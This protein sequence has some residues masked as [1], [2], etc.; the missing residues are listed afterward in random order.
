MTNNDAKQRI[1]SSGNNVNQFVGRDCCFLALLTALYSVFYVYRLGFYWDDW[2]ILK[3]FHFSDDQSMS[4]L[5]RQ[6]A[7]GFPDTVARPVQAIHLAIL[8]RV[9]GLTPLGY[10][11]VNTLTFCLGVCVFYLALRELTGRRVTSLSTITLFGLLPHYSTDRFWYAT[12]NGNISMVFY[13]LSL[14]CNVRE[15]T[16]GKRSVWKWKTM[17]AVSLVCSCLAYEVFMPLFLLNPIVCE[18]KRRHLKLSGA[19]VS[20][21]PVGPLLSFL[22]NPALLAIIS[23]FKAR[24]SPRLSGGLGLWLV[25][26]GFQASLDLTARAYLIKLPRILW[27]IFTKYWDGTAVFLAFLVFAIVASYLRGAARRSQEL[28]VRSLLLI[29]I[30]L[31]ST[32]IAGMSYAYLYSYYGIDV[33]GNNRVA[34]AAAAPVAISWIRLA[35]L[36]S[37]YAAG[38]VMQKYVFSVIVGLLCGAGCLI[39]NCVALFWIDGAQKQY[40]IMSDLKRALP[41]PPKGSSILLEGLCWTGQGLIFESGLDVR[42]A[43]PLLY[44]D[45]TIRSE[46]VRPWLKATPEGVQAGKDA[47]HSFQSLYFYDVLNKE[48]DRVMDETQA[49]AYIEKATQDDVQGC[50]TSKFGTDLPVW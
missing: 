31:G 16:T 44:E 5:L 29:C 6:L 48:A 13:F 27:S 35:Q 18:I 7:M 47:V 28:R 25:H 15:V 49:I 9:F 40:E 10:H 36:I 23:I 38:A 12:F 4:G 42:G 8:Y 14:S 39:T 46:L 45:K 24:A 32:V 21:R 11:L 17:T 26:D 3:L 22:L 30:V 41:A 50:M 37:R 43:L 20:G 1:P 34:I 19:R 2:Y 33:G